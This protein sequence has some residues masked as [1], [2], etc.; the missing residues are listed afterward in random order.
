MPRLARLIIPNQPH[1]V[2]QRGVARQAIFHD[3]Q[4]FGFWLKSFRDALVLRPMA[5]HAY[6]LMSNHL[7]LLI[8]PPDK[9]SL[10]ENMKS[11]GLR[12]TKYY[13]KR[14]ERTGP[15]WDGRFRATVIDSDRYLLECYRYIDLNPVRAHVTLTP[16]QYRWSSYAHHI[17]T[18][19]DPLVSDHSLFWAL[20]N[21][22]FERE[23]AYKALIA[24][25]VGEAIQ[26][27]I[28]AATNA[29]WALGSKQFA[30]LVAE[31]SGRRALQ[32]KRG[33]PFKAVH[34]TN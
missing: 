5:V 1:H 21:T 8:S 25:G 17:S 3:D 9:E 10:S 22:P 12:Y 32:L 14:Y 7:H 13:N 28:M 24:E 2:I 26:H 29:E 30:E 6:V 15:L 19:I 31:A 4:D 16:D 27:E 11:V 20:G 33:R 18:R 34:T 23:Q